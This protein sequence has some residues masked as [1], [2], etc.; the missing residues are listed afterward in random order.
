MLNVRMT[1]GY[2]LLKSNTQ[3]FS[4][5]PVTGSKTSPPAWWRDTRASSDRTVGA[6]TPR[7][8]RAMR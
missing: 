1:L 2:R 5:M 6:T 3:T 7:R 4:W 8:P